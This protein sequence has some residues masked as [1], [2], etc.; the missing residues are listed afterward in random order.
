M[1][2]YAVIETF[3]RSIENRYGKGDVQ[4]HLVTV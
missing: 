3:E 4:Q 2:V 1:I